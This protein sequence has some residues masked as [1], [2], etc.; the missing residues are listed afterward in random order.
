MGDL[1][2]GRIFGREAK[3][4]AHFRVVK[5]LLVEPHAG[6]G[7]LGGDR[8][9]NVDVA[10]G[11]IEIELLDIGVVGQMHLIGLDGGCSRRRIVAEIDEFDG[12]E[13]G[14]A[15]LDRLYHGFAAFLM[16]DE[17]EG[18]GA[19]RAYLEGAVFLGIEHQEGIMEERFRQTDVGRLQI[20]D[21][22][23]RILPSMAL[24]SHSS[25]FFTGSPLS[26]FS[27]VSVT[28]SK[29]ASSR[30]STEEPV[31]GSRAVLD[32]PGGIL[33]G[34]GLA[35][36]PVDVGDGEGPALEIGRDLPFR[37]KMRPG[38]I[39]GAGAGEIALDS[40][41][42]CWNRTPRKMCAGL[43]TFGTRIETLMVPPFGMSCARAGGAKGSPVILPAHM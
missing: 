19:T 11:L 7:G 10:H 3:S 17:R 6:D 5:R 24:A 25:Y 38:D 23:L 28:L 26:F 1:Q 39:V 22:G 13:M 20:E 27:P 14:A 42:R 33:G 36:M 37:G 40:G 29:I 18:A 8:F 35:V 43:S 32:V 12:L 41:G 31:L 16:L 15:A 21:Q 34:E 9:D 4:L 2:D 30:P